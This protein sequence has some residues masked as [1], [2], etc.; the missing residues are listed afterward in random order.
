MIKYKKELEKVQRS[1]LLFLAYK[2]GQPLPRYDHDYG[3][4]R[5]IQSLKCRW[6]VNDLTFLFKIINGLV[7]S[8]R[9]ISLVNFNVPERAIRHTLLFRP[10][11]Y[12]SRFGLTDP[13]SRICNLANTYYTNI[14]FFHGF[15]STFKTSVYKAVAHMVTS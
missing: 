5:G 15:P 14:N 12:T 7:C 9:V 6:I 2:V 10:H 8:S 3:P 11:I 4:M 13:I 1:F